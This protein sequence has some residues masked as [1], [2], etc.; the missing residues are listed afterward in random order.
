MMEQRHLTIL[1]NKKKCR[2][3]GQKGILKTLAVL[4]D[5]PNGE[6][7]SIYTD[8]RF[9]LNGTKPV[10]KLIKGLKRRAA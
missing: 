9:K 1:T 2:L 5:L 4:E 8:A 10:F 6:Q 3:N 7:K